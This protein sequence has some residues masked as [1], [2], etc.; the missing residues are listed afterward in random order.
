M[1]KC[2]LL[3][4]FLAQV[5][6]SSASEAKPDDFGVLEWVHNA[7]GGFYNPKQDFRYETPGDPTS[8][9]GIFANERIEKGETLCKVPWQRLLKSEDDSTEY[10]YGQSRCG[11]AV[12]REMR[13]AENSEYAP[14]ATYLNAQSEG[15]LPSA[16]SEKGK[17]LLQEILGGTP[18]EP[19]LPPDDATEWLDTDWYTRCS[20]DP[21]NKLATKAALLVI[22]R[23]DDGLMIPAYDFY[24]HRNGK[25]L[26]IETEIV[27]GTHHISKALKTIE[28]GEQLY[29]SYNMCKECT[30]RSF[31]YGT[32]GKLFRHQTAY[33]FQLDTHCLSIHSCT[34]NSFVTMGS[35]KLCLNAGIICLKTTSLTWRRTNMETGQSSG[36][37]Y[38]V[39]KRISSSSKS[40]YDEKFE[41]SVESRT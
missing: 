6:I 13:K 17:A 37:N 21:S 28:K 2:L 23:S 11:S 26:N 10:E 39:W 40:G 18:L 32:A 33:F 16:W 27:E 22:Q 38:R 25:W 41:G 1:M 4:S 35:W 5:C 3:I 14:Y 24:N 7:E 34:Q 36:K 29:I 31:G 8:V 9:A 15:Q 20:G 19:I 12:A 30:G